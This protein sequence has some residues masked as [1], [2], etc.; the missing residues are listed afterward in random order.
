MDARASGRAHPGDRGVRNQPL[1]LP[2]TASLSP[3]DGCG[4]SSQRGGRACCAPKASSGWRVVTTWWGCGLRPACR[5]AS[6][7]ADGG[8]RRYPKRSGPTLRRPCS[9]SE[10]SGTK[11]WATDVS[12]WYLSASITTRRPCARAST[13]VCG[14]MMRWPPANSRGQRTKTGFPIG[15]FPTVRSMK[16]PGVCCHV[17]SPAS[18]PNRG[19]TPGHRWCRHRSTSSTSRSGPR[20]GRAFLGAIKRREACRELIVSNSVRSSVAR[21]A[22]TGSVP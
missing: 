7:P 12:N 14:P 5:S 1:R 4:M 16:M 18:N 15:I 11:R 10:V 19:T 8:M 13:S 6:I 21:E 17:Q 3:P 22:K 9:G 2:R 20:S